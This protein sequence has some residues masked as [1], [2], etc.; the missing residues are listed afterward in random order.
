MLENKNIA[1]RQKASGWLK[2]LKEAGVLRPQKIGSTMYY[3]NYRLMELLSTD[4]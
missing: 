2:K 4:E 1:H 3:I